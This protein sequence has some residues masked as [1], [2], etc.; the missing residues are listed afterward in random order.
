MSIDVPHYRIMGKL[1]TG[2]DSTIYQ[3]KALKTG[4]I[5]AIKHVKVTTPESHK[6]IELMKDEH[7]CGSLMDHPALR[8][9]YELRLVKRRLTLKAAMLF[10]EY[11]EGKSLAELATSLSVLQA[12]YLFEKAADALAEM[13]K[14]G[15]VHADLKPGNILVMSDQNIKLI[16]FGQS[17]RINQVKPRIQGTIDYMAPE[18]E[19]KSRLDARTDVFGL[20]ATFHKV[21]TGK[22][23]ATKMNQNLDVHSLGRLGVRKSD[24][25]QPSLEEL[26]PVISK[27]IVDCCQQNPD[28][29]PKD[30]H[31]FISRCRMARLT[32]AK[33]AETE[34]AKAARKSQTDAT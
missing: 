23:I 31:D 21:L 19:S 29:R 4:V 34:E 6:T 20:G 13:H 30:M 10:M 8:K 28:K 16:D 7:Q 24:N 26:P 2:A 25:E 11:V 9:T 15:F 22:P 14:I 5:Y 12:L 3:A 32:L 33:A 1:G 18:Q 17:C 27:L